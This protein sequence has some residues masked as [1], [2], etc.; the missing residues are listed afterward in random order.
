MRRVADRGVYRW[1]VC[2]VVAVLLFTTGLS[3]DTPEKTP[4]APPPDSWA[5]QLE[6]LGT[7][8][9]KRKGAACSERCFTLTRLKLGGSASS[10]NLKFEL[11]GNLLVDGPY[12]VPL[13]GVPRH[14]RIEQA[15]ESG[16]P[17]AIGF[18]GDHYYYAATSRR[19]VLKGALV[20]DEDRA[21]SI[22]GPLNA[23]EADLTDGRCVEGT[24]LSGIT[25]ATIHFDRAITTQPSAEPTVFQLSRAVRVGREID[26]EYKLV[27]RS[28]ADLG[29]V[30]LPLAFGERVLEV[31]GAGGFRVEGTTLLLPTSG[32][33]A[34]IRIA[35]TLAQVGTFK[36]DERSPYE[37][38]LFESDAEHRVTVKSD[39]RQLDSAES[40]IPRKLPTSRL[41]LAQRGQQLEV[42]IQT[43]SSVDVLAAV[44]RSHERTV[45]LTR[46]GD[47]VSDETL[48][49]ENNGIDYLFMNPDGRPIYLATDGKAERIMHKEKGA[50]EIMVP[51][52]TGSHSVHLQALAQTGI[53]G[54]F[55]RVEVPLATYPLTASR[56]G[57]RLGLPALVYPL[58]FLGGDRAEWFLDEG[59]FIAMII[60]A[61]VAWIALRGWLRRVLGAIALGGLWF[62]AEPLFVAAIGL[63]V[64]GALVWMLGRL[65]A[66]KKLLWAMALLVMGGGFILLV[67]LFSVA[68]VPKY[69][70][71]QRYEPVPASAPAEVSEAR[72]QGAVGAGAAKDDAPAGTRAKSDAYTRRG[73]FMAQDAAGGVL[74]GVTPVALTLPQYERSV[75]ATRE[76]VTRERPFRPVLVYATAWAAWPLALGWLLCIA[77]LL[78]MYRPLLIALLGRIRERLARGSAAPSAGS[79]P[80]APT[81]A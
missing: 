16:K 22:P 46:K 25:G 9:G 47:L 39:A 68:V 15:T 8:V 81:A 64:L 17:A 10:G 55:G 34:D 33:S 76:L 73:N 41:Y 3:A 56:V 2:A 12:P 67:A 26:F 29:V 20:L 27:M 77:A 21:L 78:R 49:Y 45:V 59:D 40:P 11:E 6:A 53:G 14:V 79:P 7:W 65:L 48:G 44:V 5:G 31:T 51:L 71:A 57:V 28:G 43:L 35:G 54:L 4:P 60:A 61:A 50:E 13:F 19:F 42:S 30:R 75:Y 80:D 52:R 1:F 23:L 62:I 24:R 18:E 72:E 74:E 32:H 38:W 66:G 37:W 36:P 70:A 69:R 58:A 63:I